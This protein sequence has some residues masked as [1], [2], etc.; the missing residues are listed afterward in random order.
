M[1]RDGRF[2]SQIIQVVTFFAVLLALTAVGAT[3][4]TLI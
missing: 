2:R 1:S 4:L 3:L